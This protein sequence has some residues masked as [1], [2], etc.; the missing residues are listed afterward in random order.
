MR[1]GSIA[2]AIPTTVVV[3]GGLVSVTC[4]AP[5]PASSNVIVVGI[6]SSPTNLDP[7]FGLDDVSQKLHQLI[8]DSLIS[9]DDQMRPRL[10]LAESFEAP[11]PITYV[12]AVRPGIRFHDGHELTAAD[13]V[14]TFGT[15]LDPA[16]A[17]P[18]RGALD[19]LASVQALD[20]YRVR[21]EL[22]EPFA[23]FPINLALSIV[24]D[25]AGPELSSRPN[26][27]GPYRFRSAAVDEEVTLQSFAEHWRGAPRNDGLRLKVV[28]DEMMRALEV[29][30]GSMDLVVNDVSPDIYD[31]MRDEPSIRTSTSDGVD[32]QYIGVN[33]RDPMLSDRRVRQAIAYAIDQ[34]AI[35]DHL[36]RGLARRANGLL[37]P[38]SWAHAADVRPYD[39]DPARA[40]RLL[41]AAGYTDPDGD[42]SLPRLR[43]SLK[44][45]N[46][47]F[48]R[49]QSAV[50][51]EQL[52][53]VGIALDVRAYE[54]AT[55]FA[56]VVA[57][58]FQLFTLQWTAVSLADPDILRRVFHSTQVPPVGFNRGYYSSPE[59]DDRL[60]RAGRSRDEHERRAL[61][62]DAQRILA[63]DLPYIPL[64]F[65]TNFAIARHDVSGVALNPFADLV[66]LRHVSRNGSSARP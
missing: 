19:K 62:A 4:S 65:K 66:F 1:R 20:R 29:R 50:L 57:G 56:D 59:L 8:Y 40:R 37:P 51:Q 55:L 38:L 7:R 21:F 5:R 64:W 24:P 2:G 60:D 30:H 10:E 26:G 6:T 27:T 31:Q 15:M 48:N 11:T 22:S 34:Q 44:V 33:L 35:V 61:F 28:P 18:R 13:V 25:G 3:L 16:L 17:S 23:S 53:A 49:L 14:H 36:R 52:R 45:S 9:L 42:G 46:L 63:E 47:E 32:C 58:N 12:V 39:H 43:V 41:D 54:F